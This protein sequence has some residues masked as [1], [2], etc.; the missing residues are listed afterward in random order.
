[1]SPPDINVCFAISTEADASKLS[2][3][4]DHEERCHERNPDAAQAKS[5]CALHPYVEAR[6]QGRFG[7]GLGPFL[8]CAR[9]GSR[10]WPIATSV[11]AG[12]PDHRN[13]MRAVAAR[14]P[15]MWTGE[16]RDGLSAAFGDR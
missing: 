2:S 7:R 6:P 14:S 5:A 10:R 12:L 3:G 15:V 1:M 4:F 13:A 9:T 11:G 8:R 16:P